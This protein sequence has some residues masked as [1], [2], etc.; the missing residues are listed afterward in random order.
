MDS[1]SDPQEIFIKFVAVV[2]MEEIKRSVAQ[3]LKRHGSL[4][5]GLLLG[6]LGSLAFC[7]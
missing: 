1:E 2:F 7:I 5:A 4:I 3:F 6:I